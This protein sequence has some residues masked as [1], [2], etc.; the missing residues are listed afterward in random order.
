MLRPSAAREALRLGPLVKARWADAS[1]VE[2]VPRMTALTEPLVLFAGR[3]IAER[4]A[5]ARRFRSIGLLLFLK[6]AIQYVGFRCP[7][8]KTEVLLMRLIGLLRVAF[9]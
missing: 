4:A 5:D 6:L 7:S 1:R 9:A 3:P 8:H 2:C